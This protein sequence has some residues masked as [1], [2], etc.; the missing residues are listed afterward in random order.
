MTRYLALVISVKWAFY[1]YSHPRHPLGDNLFCVC[2]RGCREIIL[3]GLTGELCGT[4]SCLSKWSQHNATGCLLLP[5]YLSHFNVNQS[6]IHPWFCFAGLRE[7]FF[8]KHHWWQLGNLLT[9][10]V[11]LNDHFSAMLV[12]TPRRV[13]C[14]LI[15]LTWGSLDWQARLG[16]CQAQNWASSTSI[17]E[18]LFS[19][20]QHFAPLV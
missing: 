1:G 4:W 17:S 10:T 5:L 15:S 3:P 18:H 6:N 12:E 2:Q 9:V 11:F 19:N 20:H 14:I 13:V 8:S 16:Q 7:L